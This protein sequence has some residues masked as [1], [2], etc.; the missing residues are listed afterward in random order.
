MKL[1]SVLK[2]VVIVTA[3]LSAVGCA[4]ISGTA[5]KQIDLSNQEWDKYA[6]GVIGYNPSQAY[7]KT[8]VCT[9]LTDPRCDDRDY[10]AVLLAV[11]FRYVSGGHG[12]WALVNKKDLGDLAPAD[13]TNGYTFSISNDRAFFGKF[14]IKK[15][16]LAEYVGLVSKPGEKGPCRWSGMR[17]AGGTVCESLGFDSDTAKLPTVRN[18]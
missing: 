13:Y 10:V 11:E 9:G 1:V 2:S 18:F 7:K 6:Y 5:A 16:Q 3:A 4:S 14:E 17:G 12:L 8:I 15:G